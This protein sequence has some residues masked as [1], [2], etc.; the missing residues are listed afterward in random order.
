MNELTDILIPL[1]KGSRHN[2]LELVYCLRSIE[3]HLKGVGNVFI[4]GESPERVKNCMHVSVKDSP[5]NWDRAKNIYRKIRRCC[6]LPDLS[7][8]FLFMNDDHFLL[9]D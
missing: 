8:N 5:N 4:V 3:K 2:D 7:D 6:S 9:S 1:G